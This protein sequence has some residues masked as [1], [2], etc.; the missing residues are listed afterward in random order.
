[1]QNIS[2]EGEH[3]GS[4]FLLCRTACAGTD[5]LVFNEGLLGI[6]GGEYAVVWNNFL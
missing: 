3:L 6:G 5:N 4:P 1:L 2:L